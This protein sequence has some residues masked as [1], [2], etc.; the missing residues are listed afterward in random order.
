MADRKVHRP[1]RSPKACRTSTAIRMRT[2]PPTECSSA[3]ARSPFLCVLS[4]VIWWALP[5]PSPQSLKIHGQTLPSPTCLAL[6]PCPLRACRRRC[7]AAI[8]PRSRQP[9]VL[10]YFGWMALHLGH[11][12]SCLCCCCHANQTDGSTSSGGI[13][14]M[15]NL[16]GLEVPKKAPSAAPSGSRRGGGS[17]ASGSRSSGSQARC[18]AHYSLFTSH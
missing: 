15:P 13:P 6:P 10:G 14:G 16:D 1:E 18:S 8:P 3:V 11:L 12:L 7:W 5:L 4:R 2:R 9:F 17:R